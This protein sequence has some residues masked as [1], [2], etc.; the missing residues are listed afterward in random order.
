ML[1][2]ED[3]EILNLI[4]DGELI[5]TTPDHPFYTDDG[6]WVAAGELAVGAEIVTAGD[7]TVESVPIHRGESGNGDNSRRA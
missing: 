6:E 7:D 1:V 3:E 2:H 4:V 5:V